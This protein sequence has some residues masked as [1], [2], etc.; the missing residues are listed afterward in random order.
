MIFLY[1]KDN[2]CFGKIQRNN[3]VKLE[4]IQGNNGLNSDKI[5]MKDI[6]L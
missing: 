2:Q 1:R 6:A 5:Q 3:G 4:K